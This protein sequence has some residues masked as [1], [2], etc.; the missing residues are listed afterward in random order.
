MQKADTILSI[1]NQESVQ[2]KQYVFSR[3][4]RHLFNPDFFMET[5]RKMY[6]KPGNMTPG[7]DGKTIDGFKKSK[8]TE[9]IAKLRNEQ[10]YPTPVR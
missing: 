1:L 9:L 3:I 8:V 10:Y 6:A 4:Y 7:T 2:N 5:Y